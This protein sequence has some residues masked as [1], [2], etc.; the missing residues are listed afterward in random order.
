M[1]SVRIHLTRVIL[2]RA[3]ARISDRLAGRADAES[4]DPYGHNLACF[5]QRRVR[6]GRKP[7]SGGQIAEPQSA[8]PHPIFKL[9]INKVVIVKYSGI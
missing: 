5:A 9:L 6:R 8:H 7:V 4:K 1:S 3:S 2:S